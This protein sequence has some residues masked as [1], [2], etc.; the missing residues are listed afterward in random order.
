MTDQ[1]RPLAKPSVQI[2]NDRVIV[3]E[4]RFAPGAE[5][6]WHRQ[7]H[8]YIVVVLTAGKLMQETA[9]GEIVTELAAGQSYAREAGV[10]AVFLDGVRDAVGQNDSV[11]AADDLVECDELFGA[12]EGAGAVVDEDMR[13]V[14]RKRREGVHDRVLSLASSVNEHG[15]SGC[16]GGKLHH[17]ALVAVNDDVEVSDTALHE[18]GRGM[19][20]DW[21]SGEGGED[22]VDDGTRHAGAAAGG[23]EDGGGTGHGAWGGALKT[24][25]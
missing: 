21:T 22:F 15:G 8:D 19:C 6:G 3:T 11:F 12:Y 4:W 14:G 24:E 13:D 17:L 7:A 10:V 5:T 18:G 23:E 1:N 16:V 9:N 20:K 2:E 25:G